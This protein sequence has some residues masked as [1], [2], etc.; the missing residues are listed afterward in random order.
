MTQRMGRRLVTGAAIACL[1]AVAASCNTTAPIFV[2]SLSLTIQSGGN[3]IRITETVQV[4]ATARLSDDTDEDVTDT[5]QWQSLSASVVTV[6][7]TG[8]VTGVGAGS[9][10]IRAT[11]RG[12]TAV[13][14]FSVQ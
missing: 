7:Q 13:F 11:H 6:S 2:R 14:S 1:C 10:N 3:V 4:R 9:G 5:A 8:I 12:A